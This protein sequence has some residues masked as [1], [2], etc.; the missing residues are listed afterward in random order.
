MGR[1][2]SRLDADRTAKHPSSQVEIS[3]LGFWGTRYNFDQKVVR[4]KF[5]SKLRENLSYFFL[6]SISSWTNLEHRNTLGLSVA[7]PKTPKG[8]RNAVS[9]M[10]NLGNKPGCPWPNPLLPPFLRQSHRTHISLYIALCLLWTQ[11]HMCPD[12]LW[13]D[14]QACLIQN[15][16]LA[17]P[18]GCKQLR[19]SWKS[20]SVITLT[21]WSHLSGSYVSLLINSTV[22]G[23]W[24][25][26]AAD[27]TSN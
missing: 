5:I 18:L 27:K 10:D 2:R 7:H 20:L 26:L 3:E 6:V 4:P 23:S 17:S 14:E 22:G 11:L 21:F 15:E 19:P 13:L 12:V 1:G 24:L 16:A 8:K 25:V 9:L